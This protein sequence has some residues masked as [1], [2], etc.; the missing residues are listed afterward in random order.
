MKDLTLIWE[1]DPEDEYGNTVRVVDLEGEIY[2]LF[3]FESSANESYPINFHL[4]QEGLVVFTKQANN[5]TVYGIEALQDLDLPSWTY[6]HMYLNGELKFV[7]TC[8]YKA[9]YT[10]EV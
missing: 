5:T 10:T 7:L 4:K 1:L 3:M 9:Y 6:C 2:E 8:P